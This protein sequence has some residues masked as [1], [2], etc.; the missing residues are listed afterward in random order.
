MAALDAV[1]LRARADE[2][3]S[4]LS[5]FDRMRVLLARALARRPRYLIVREPDVL[6]GREAVDDLL[7]LLRRLARADRLGVVVSLA[8]GGEGLTAADRV[9]VLGD[10]L[11]LFHG[12]VGALAEAG[13]AWRAGMV[14]T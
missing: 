10:G 4:G 13:S 5:R 8:N 14:A 9:L 1:G 11:L 6:I 3:V 2:P 12:R 7:G